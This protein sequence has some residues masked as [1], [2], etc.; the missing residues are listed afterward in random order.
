MDRLPFHL[1]L[2]LPL[3]TAVTREP[4][5]T[6]DSGVLPTQLPAWATISILV[7]PEAS[8][9]SFGQPSTSQAAPSTT[10]KNIRRKAQREGKTVCGI[11][12]EHDREKARKEVGPDGNPR[13]VRDG[14]VDVTRFRAD[15]RN[16]HAVNYTPDGFNFPG[17][18]TAPDGTVK[19]DARQLRRYYLEEK[20]RAELNPDGS[21]RFAD[22]AGNLDIRAYERWR[23]KNQAR[24]SERTPT[25]E[26]D[27][28]VADAGNDWMHAFSIDHA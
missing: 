27:L 28:P 1:P 7:T 10:L 14:K 21:L 23:T 9:A 12:Y 22:T 17:R 16:L 25:V 4:I 18:V 24:P 26:R 5:T 13:Y 19:G 2:P 15:R 8:D 6:T 20:A 11:R 3:P